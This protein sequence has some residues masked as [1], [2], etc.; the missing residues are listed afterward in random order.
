MKKSNLVLIIVLSVVIVGLITGLVFFISKAKQK[1]AEIAEVVEMMNFEKEQV[2]QEFQDLTY[3]FAGYSATIKNDSLFQLLESEKLKVNQLL[4]ELRITK[5]TNARRIS[6]LKKELATVRSVMIHYVNQI[7]SLN[8]ENKELKTK[9][10]EVNRKYN[11]VSQQA[12]RLSKEKET[13]SEVV[14]RASKLDVVNFSMQTLNSRGRKTTWFTQ[15]ANLQF[16][17]TINKNITTDP[18]NKTLYVRLTRP[19]SEVMTKNP[20]HLFQFEDK[21]IAYSLSKNFEYEGESINDMIYWK[22]E[23]VMQKGNYR[24][25]FFVDGSLVGSFEFEIKK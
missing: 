4:E 9:N 6:E 18:G 1:E 12:E 5:S 22:V 11:Q 3:E 16:N 15:V 2:E 17:Y 8:A 21:K 25:D 14:T 19:D 20:N 13:L 10:V 24:A 23:E 7:D